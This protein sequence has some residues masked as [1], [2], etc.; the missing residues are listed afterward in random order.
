MFSKKQIGRIKKKS[1]ALILSLSVASNIFVTTGSDC[2]ASNNASQWNLIWSDEFD[3][4]SLNRNNWNVE[5]NGFGGGNEEL[6]YYCDRP[7]NIQVGDGTLKLIARK[8]YYYGPDNREKDYTSARLNTLNKV[9]IGYGK[10]EARIKL[11]KFK[12]AFPA[13]WMLGANFG[14]VGYPDC[15]EIDIV[16]TV[17][18]E[19]VPYGTAHWP[20]GDKKIRSS[21]SNLSDIGES[22]DTSQWH[23]YSIIRDEKEITWYVDGMK[24]HK[25]A[26]ESIPEREAITKNMELLLNFAIGGTWPGFDIDD[27]ALPA[28][29]E[30][31]YVRYYEKN[32]DYVPTYEKQDSLD[33]YNGT[34]QTEV[35]DWSAATGQIV[36]RQNPEDGFLAEITKIGND[37]WGVQASLRNLDYVRGNTYTLKCKLLSDIDKYVF[38]KIQGD[39]TSTIAGEYVHLLANTEL[40]YETTFNIPFEY[41]GSVSIYFAMGG[42]ANGEDISI[43]SPMNLSVSDVEFYTLVEKEQEEIVEP[44]LTIDGFQMNTVLGAFRTVYKIKGSKDF[45]EKDIVD[46]GLVYAIGD[47]P[48]DNIVAT[49]ISAAVVPFSATLEKGLRRVETEANLVTQTFVM[50]MEMIPNK[51]F[52]QENMTMRAYAKLKDGTYIY[53]EPCTTTM[54]EIA[55]YLYSNRKMS[56]QAAYQYL[57]NEI[58][59]SV[60]PEY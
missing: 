47:E 37:E 22:I 51:L 42:K 2:M 27:T 32:A 15:G 3:G 29:M 8:E 39:G 31:D 55:D 52:Y 4:S 13:F 54:Y 30:V 19:S 44:K 14:E 1:V 41:T 57:Y 9:E 53:S 7:E 12:G 58:L 50:T 48:V 16:E 36:T 24:Y 38:V 33:N 11:P 26:L 43:R 6:Q 10:V 34:W 20:I 46:R 17:N 21:G 25:V 18:E 23:I 59:K 60:N 35:A 5:V 45:L 40:S 49:N 28:T 56:T